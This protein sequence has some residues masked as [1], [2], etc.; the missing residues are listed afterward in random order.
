MMGCLFP[1]D[2]DELLQELLIWGEFED[3]NGNEASET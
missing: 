1:N 3:T 2:T